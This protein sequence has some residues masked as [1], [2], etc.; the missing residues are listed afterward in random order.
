MGITSI[1]R[2]RNPSMNKATVIKKVGFVKVKLLKRNKTAGKWV[3][4]SS[5]GVL[6]QY[7][8]NRSVLDF[9][10]ILDWY[11]R[12]VRTHIFYVQKIDPS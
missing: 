1:K 3:G 4:P 5:V 8:C 12:Q 11:S 6:A 2:A 7:V 10:N 9:Y